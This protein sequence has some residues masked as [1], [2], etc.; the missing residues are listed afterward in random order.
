VSFT[1]DFIS[2]H[3]VFHSSVHCTQLFPITFLDLCVYIP[4][5][6]QYLLQGRLWGLFSS[7]FV[8]LF[9]VLIWYD[10]MW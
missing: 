2:Q 4:C 6:C 3:S 10:M 9:W 1:F 8:V 7:L 5:L